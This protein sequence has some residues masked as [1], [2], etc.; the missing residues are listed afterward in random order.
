MINIEISFA[1]AYI[2][3]ALKETSRG[4][5][6]SKHPGHTCTIRNRE[7]IFVF[8]FFFFL[9]GGGGKGIQY[10]NDNMQVLFISNYSYFEIK[11]KL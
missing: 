4:E 11:N 7:T 5:S 8:F 1:I 6:T 10:F 3:G 9:G 2:V